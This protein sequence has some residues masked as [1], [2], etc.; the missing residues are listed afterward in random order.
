MWVDADSTRLEQI[1][2]NLLNN[3]VKY[4]DGGGQIWLTA[5]REEGEVVIRVRDTGI[6]IPA[7][8]LSQIFELFAQGDRSLA[9]QEGGLGIGLTLARSLAELHG[10]S[11][12]ATSDGPDKGSVFM[13]RLPAAERPSVLSNPDRLPGGS[14]WGSGSRVMVVD[15]NLELALGLARL[16]KLLGH[17]VKM[18]HDGPTALEAARSFQPEVVL[19]DIG[20]P[21]LD[22]YQV[23]TILRQ[24]CCG[25]RPRIIAITGY[26]HEE[27][28]RRSREAGFD[29]HLVKPIEF[30]SLVTLLADTTACRKAPASAREPPRT[31]DEASRDLLSLLSVRPCLLHNI[32]TFL[33]SD[34]R[35]DACSTFLRRRS[36]DV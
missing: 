17:D 3:A 20:L 14:A 23:A 27:D 6:G 31:F 26:G 35:D 25:R 7:E 1:L 12:G 21:G 8:K 18:A 11:L 4:T 16:L 28:R 2:T 24:E 13:V 19:L 34:L 15:D 32:L 9:R 29:Y 10:G 36:P 5:F 33:E 22:G 30:R